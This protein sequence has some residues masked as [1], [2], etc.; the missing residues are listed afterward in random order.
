MRQMPRVL[1]AL[2]LPLLAGACLFPALASAVELYKPG[3]DKDPQVQLAR[4]LEADKRFFSAIVELQELARGRDPLQMPI[5]Y[6]LELANNYV[7]F[8]MRDRAESLYRSLLGSNIDKQQLAQGFLSLAEFDFQRGYTA[9]ARATLYRMRDKLP[10]GMLPAWQDLMARVLMSE[11]RYAEAIDV[12][13]K[14]DNASEQSPFTRYNLGVALVNDGRTAQGQTV[15]DKVGVR[16]P[17]NALELSLRDRAN[18]SLGWQFLQTRQG[19]TAEPILSRVSSEGPFAN[20]ALLG[21]GWAQLA[22]QGERIRKSGPADDKIPDKN[23]YTTFSTLGVLI[24]PGFLNSDIFDRGGVGM[25]SFRLRKNKGGEEALKRALVP[26]TILIARDPMDPAVQEAW[27]AIPYTLD[28]LGAHAQAL[29][30]YEKAIEVLEQSRKR[31]DEAKRSIKI[32]RM[33]ETIV[34]RDADAESGWQWKLRDLPDAP[35]TYFLQN[36]LTQHSFQEG[37]KN[38]R[39]LRMLDRN[40]MAWRNRLNVIQAE[41]AQRTPQAADADAQITRALRDSDP[42][43]PDLTV[44]LQMDNGMVAPG[45]YNQRAQATNMLVPALDLAGA[46]SR[47]NGPY[48]RVDMLRGRMN[49]LHAQLD[50]TARKQASLLEAMATQEL[51]GQRRQIE[52]YMAE[53]R[54]ALARLYDRQQKGQLKD[55]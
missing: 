1:R 14:D 3:S 17:D 41:Y 33:V 16:D 36:L 19:G 45:S 18:L 6:R 48:E 39:D 20:R 34:R 50:A 55:E 47:F 42:A 53:A 7:G 8:G 32:G 46:P 38:Y 28:Q 9:E 12:L 26:W 25:G 22:P 54:F 51:D 2:C 23:S 35:E 10:K 52:R 49:N 37:L 44:G 21:L 4:F 27:L 24:R 30:Y 31:M 13:T 40:I 15:L 11:R 29:Q 5:D 43:Y